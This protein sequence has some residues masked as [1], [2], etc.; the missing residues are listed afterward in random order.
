MQN[1]EISDIYKWVWIVLIILAV[2]LGAKTL[3]ELK[4]LRNTDP[5]YNSI[6]V[7][8]DGE[9]VSVPDIATFSF[10]ISADAQSVSDAQKKV[11]EKVGVIL[12][13]LEDLDI[14]E[15]DIKT[16][17]YSVWPKY[18]YETVMLYPCTPYNCP[19]S[20]GKQVQDGYTANHSITV[21]VR[22]TEDVGKVLAD[23]GDSGATN[24]SGITFTVDDPDKL[25]KEARAKAIANAK[26]KA[27]TLAEELDVKLVRV[28]SFSDSTDSG[29][30]PVYMEKEALNMGE[31][32]FSKSVPT[33]PIGENKVKIVVN[34]TYEI[35]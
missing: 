35:R 16:T 10:T 13:S 20:P 14:E 31:F 17:N 18:S 21:K 11:A 24:L 23:V 30:M 8:G 9:A 34:I 32:N 3:G 29:P 6:T 22:K 4:S 27:E 19:P 1:K 2:F 25:T 28:V 7:T 5:A 15:K 12:A 33:I 26:E